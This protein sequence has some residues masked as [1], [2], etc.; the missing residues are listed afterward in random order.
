MTTGTKTLSVEELYKT[1]EWPDK[2]DGFTHSLFVVCEDTQAL[3]RYLHSDYHLKDWIAIA[4]KY[5]KGIVVFD[6]EI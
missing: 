6:S 5:G 4:K 3:K 1:V 2:R